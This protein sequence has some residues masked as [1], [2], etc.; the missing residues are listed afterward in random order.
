[1]QGRPTGLSPMGSTLSYRRNGISTIEVLV[2]MLIIMLA[3]F[4]ITISIQRSN[5]VSQQSGLYQS[6]YMTVLSLKDALVVSQ[7]I[8]HPLSGTL[9]GF[10]YT[11]QCRNVATKTLELDRKMSLY[12]ID[13]EIHR[14]NFAK[15]YRFLQMDA[16]Q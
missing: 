15:H 2:A 6:L 16:D 4:L 1:M 10:S 14:N 13:L 8:E 7:C 12:Q 3:T 11:M 9:N 5:K